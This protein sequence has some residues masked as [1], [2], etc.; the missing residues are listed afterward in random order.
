MGGCLVDTHD[1]S[2]PRSTSGVRC[3]RARRSVRSHQNRP[4]S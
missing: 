2:G 4:S 1:G 3:R